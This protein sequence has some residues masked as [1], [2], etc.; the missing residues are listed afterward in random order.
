M[1]GASSVSIH[2][3]SRNTVVNQENKYP[4]PACPRLQSEVS[5]GKCW[6]KP[7]PHRWALRALAGGLHLV[8]NKCALLGP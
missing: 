3:K 7:F 1:D 4:Q 2:K 8:G 5:R 6:K